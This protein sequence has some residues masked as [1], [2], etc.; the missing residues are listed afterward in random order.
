MIENKSETAEALISGMRGPAK[1]REKILHYGAEDAAGGCAARL[2]E[3]L[4]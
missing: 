2:N 1:L 4:I 3:T